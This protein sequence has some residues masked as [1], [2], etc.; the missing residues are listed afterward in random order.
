VLNP[1]RRFGS[2]GESGE[3]GGIE[4]IRGVMNLAGEPASRRGRFGVA[5]SCCWRSRL[6]AVPNQNIEEGA[7]PK[8]PTRKNAAEEAGL[9]EHQRKT[10]LR[11]AS[12]SEEESERRLLGFSRTPPQMH[13]PL[14]G[15]VR[16]HSAGA[17]GRLCCRSGQ[18]MH[19]HRHD[20]H[21]R[22]TVDVGDHQCVPGHLG[23]ER[24]DAGRVRRTEG[25]G[26][27]RGLRQRV[28]RPQLLDE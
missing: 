5:V 25:C 16:R 10:A 8:V 14:V 13:E 22:E 11:I 15:R 17:D 23:V 7:Y 27:M 26:Q 18:R 2:S 24:G 20:H 9:S 3:A 28:V 1:V 4:Q 12:I 21:Q 6:P 19:Q